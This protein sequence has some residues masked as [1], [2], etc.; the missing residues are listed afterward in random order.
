MGLSVAT[1]KLTTVSDGHS[2]ACGHRDSLSPANL[3]GHQLTHTA[4]QCTEGRGL[5][6][7]VDYGRLDWMIL[8]VF[9]KLSD[10]VIQ[11]SLS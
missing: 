4:T 1:H 9:S 8:G 2:D 10:Y 5:V 3:P 7:N 6:G 11:G